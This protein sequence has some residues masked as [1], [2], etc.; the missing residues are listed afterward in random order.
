MELVEALESI[1]K[2][3]RQD[4]EANIR[5]LELRIE[6]VRRRARAEVADLRTT[7]ATLRKFAGM[8]KRK[9][10]PAPVEHKPSDEACREEGQRQ[11]DKEPQPPKPL[12]Q[13]QRIKKYLEDLGRPATPSLIAVGTGILKSSVSSQLAQHH[14]LFARAD[15]GWTVKERPMS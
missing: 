9:A 3:S 14:E 13:V 4:V 10:G 7:I 2:A 11:A 6:T 15:D 1:S 8:G 5:E 12:S